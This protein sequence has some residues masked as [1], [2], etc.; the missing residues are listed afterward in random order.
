MNKKQLKSLEGKFSGAGKT[1]PLLVSTISEWYDA[2]HRDPSKEEIALINS[3]APEACPHCG[4]PRLSKDGFQKKTGI[5]V[6]RCRA[7]GRKFGPLTGT[8]FDS[9]KIPIS[10]WVEFLVHLFEFHSVAT[11]A[12][13]NR[14]ADSTGHYWLNKVFLVLGDYQEGVSFSDVVWIDEAYVPVWKS[15]K[16]K[17]GGG[18]IFA[19]SR[20]TNAAS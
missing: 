14:N 11:S 15:E 20:G 1:G 5:R 6:Y 16:A 2:K 3:V 12:E 7:C 19:A 13:D 18:R 8:V 4:S 10:E 9:R 17:G